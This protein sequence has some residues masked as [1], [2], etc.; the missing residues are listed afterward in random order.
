M[1]KQYLL[2]TRKFHSVQT[3]IVNKTRH[4]ILFFPPFIISEG[5]RGRGVTDKRLSQSCLGSRS[6]LAQ[7]EKRVQTTAF[8]AQ[9][10]AEEERHLARTHLALASTS[11]IAQS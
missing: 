5:I 4:S 1:N 10:H 8:P 11:S 2:G 9:V 6:A 3:F 7:S